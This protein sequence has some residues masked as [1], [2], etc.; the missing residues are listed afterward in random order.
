MQRPVPTPREFTLVL[1]GAWAHG[2]GTITDHR[3]SSCLIR[4]DCALILG[5][6]TTKL[7]RLDT[8]SRRS[9]STFH[10]WC[11]GGNT[12]G[13][14]GSL[15]RRTDNRARAKAECSAWVCA[16]STR[17]PPAAP[18]PKEHFC[19]RRSSRGPPASLLVAVPVTPAMMA[20]R[21]GDGHGRW[22]AAWRRRGW[23]HG[24]CARAGAMGCSMMQGGLIARQRD[25]R[26]DGRDD[27][28]DGARAGAS[29]GPEGRAQRPP[30]TGN[31]ASRCDPRRRARPTTRR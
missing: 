25:G 9:F 18:P 31:G 3:I 26:D 15:R 24:G 10:D 21:H 8:P 7:S 20:Q 5:R 2:S 12:S 30:P 29:P 11:S 28:G 17:H 23:A 6:N 4:P 27:A 22:P 13:V 1:V 19:M 14:V 16:A